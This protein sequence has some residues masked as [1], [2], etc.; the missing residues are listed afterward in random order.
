MSERV[1]AVQT[2]LLFE[3]L[4]RPCP[5]RLP[6]AILAEA[7]QVI[8]LLGRHFW[9]ATSPLQSQEHSIENGGLTAM[10]KMCTNPFAAVVACVL[11]ASSTALQARQ[12]ASVVPNSC[13]AMLLQILQAG[14][15]SDRVMEFS[16]GHEESFTRFLV[17]L[18][19]QLSVL[20]LCWLY[21]ADGGGGC[22]YRTA[23]TQFGEARSGTA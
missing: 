21:Y 5:V 2:T 3:L 17:Y 12:T 20:I 10:S 6:P 7:G 22:S 19:A 16:F 8:D 15:A 1:L 14:A 11:G 9:N 18:H 13:V 4:P 23:R